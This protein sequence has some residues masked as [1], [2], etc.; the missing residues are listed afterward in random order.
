VDRP[1]R[2]D[3]LAASELGFLPLDQRLDADAASAF[4]QQL[5]DL[6]QGRDRQVVAQPGAGVEIADRRRDAAVIKVPDYA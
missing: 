1:R 4:E 2:D 3:H 6:G 5:L